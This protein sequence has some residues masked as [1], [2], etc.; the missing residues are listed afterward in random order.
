MR[1]YV[2][3]TE[4]TDRKNGEIIEAALG[5]FPLGESLFED[6]ESGLIPIDLRFDLVSVQ[7]YKPAGEISFGAMAVH[8]I[9][10]H[11]LEGCPPTSSFK[12]PED[13]AYLIGHSIDFDWA[14]AGSPANVKRICTH[15]MAQHVWPDATGHS[16]SALTYM[17]AGANDE[18]RKMLRDA[19]SAEVDIRI[20]RL[21]LANILL[22]RPE[23]KM[24]SQLWEYS[25]EC[26]IPLTCPMKRYEG[27]KLEEL[28]RGFVYWCLNQPW[29]DPY[30]RKGLMRVLERDR[31][32]AIA[33]GRVFAGDEDEAEDGDEFD[34][35]FPF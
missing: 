16:Q 27:V 24:W 13:C 22:A 21:L 4:T 23:I 10:P 26:R 30:F 14:A 8:H 17:L 11:E 33:S 29:L 35:A 25:E 6:H 32:A 31:N 18:V 34:R 5:R 20:N 7:R 9:L 12:L 15:A 2:F 28:D 19:H 3:D 1:A